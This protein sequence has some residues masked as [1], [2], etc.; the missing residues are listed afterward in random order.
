MTEYVFVGPEV[1]DVLLLEDTLQQ[2]LSDGSGCHG[3]AMWTCVQ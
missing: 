1:V 2:D 3:L